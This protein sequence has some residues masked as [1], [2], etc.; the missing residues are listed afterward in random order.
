M[1]NR[2]PFWLALFS[3]IL[4]AGSLMA[5]GPMADNWWQALMPVDILVQATRTT[6][7][8]PC[9]KAEKAK[10]VN[11][12]ERGFVLLQ[13]R[14]PDGIIETKKIRMVRGRTSSITFNLGSGRFFVDME[15]GKP[16]T[17][18][19][20]E[21]ET[22]TEIEKRVAAQIANPYHYV[23]LKPELV[24]TN[25]CIVIRSQM[26]QGMVEALA[27]EFHKAM[28]N[29]DVKYIRAI[30]DYYIRKAD[31]IMLGYL[32][33]TADGRLMDDRLADTIS[34]EY[35][36]TPGEFE[37]PN[38]EKFILATNVNA[39]T[40]FYASNLLKNNGGEK[41]VGEATRTIIRIGLAFCVLA[42]VVWFLFHAKFRRWLKTV[43]KS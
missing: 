2:T 9:L 34:T 17:P 39:S 18:I 29:F 31:G 38:L 16:T 19:K 7:A 3:A 5:V 6:E 41:R 14:Q 40:L 1:E 11:D 21:F 12:P 10:T 42:P 27:G 33:R 4:L 30:K 36:L 15:N 26:S 20:D 24:G 25:G 37:V 43:N 35:S 28:P 13:R 32:G 8:V 22:D 23:L